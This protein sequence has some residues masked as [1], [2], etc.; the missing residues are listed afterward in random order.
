MWDAPGMQRIK[1]P[2]GAMNAEQLEVMAELA[3]EYSDGIAH[4][5]LRQDLQLHFIH[6][7]DVI[8]LQRRLSDGGITTREACGNSVRNVTACPFAGVCRTESFDVTPYRSR[9]RLLLAWDI[10]EHRTT[11]WKFK[12]AFSGCRDEAL[13]AGAIHDIGAIAVIRDGK[14]GFE[15]WVGGGLGSV[16]Y[17]AKLYDEFISEEELL[18]VSLAIGRVFARLGEKKN[19]QTARLKFVVAKLGIE[20]FRQE[21][22][23]ERAA[24][25][26]DPRWTS[27]LSELHEYDETPLRNSS[28]LLQI[29][30]AGPEGFGKWL[31]SNTYEQRQAGYR[32]VAVALPLG[33]IT[34]DQL[35]SL[36]DLARQYV[37]ET[38]RLTVEQNIVLRWVAESDLAAVYEALKAAGLATP[39][40]GGISDIA[41][42]PGTDT[43]KLGISSSRGLSSELRSRLIQRLDSLDP[44]VRQLRIKVSGCFNSCGQHQAADLGFYGVNR[45]K[46]GYHVPHFQVVLGGQWTHNGGSYGLAIGAVPSKH[47]PEAVDVIL[48]RY[49]SDKTEDESFQAFIKHIRQAGIARRCWSR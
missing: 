32:T 33:D 43:C 45:N 4:V 35:R 19:R 16:P 23:A 14:R 2:F 10:P 37:R 5:A 15:F 13:Q 36:A 3:E 27:Y 34:S 1:I 39:G 44:A 40:A 31:E 11:A 17:Q 49:L 22:E 20:K 6:I 9:P 25:E 30:P 18:P 47:V 29:Q 26:F 38:V 28:G 42:C 46:N 24:L 48:S 41:S 7:D 12:I 21:V 8:A